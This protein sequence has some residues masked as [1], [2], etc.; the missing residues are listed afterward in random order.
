MCVISIIENKNQI[1]SNTMVDKMY[2]ENPHY[3]GIAYFNENS[4]QIYYKKV[5]KQKRLK[6]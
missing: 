3:S 1:P 2:K 4:K 5:L 6:K